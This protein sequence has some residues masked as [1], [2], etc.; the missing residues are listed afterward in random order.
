MNALLAVKASAPPLR[1]GLRVRPGLG[2]FLVPGGALMAAAL[3]GCCISRAAGAP[4]DAAEFGLPLPEGKGVMWEDPR[5]IHRVIVRFR[6]TVPAADR[7]HI[8]YWGSWWPD[9][10][11]PKDREPGGGDMGWMELGNW[12]KYGW[13]KADTEATTEGQTLSLTFRPVNASEFPKVKDYP[14]PFR[15][16]L[17]VRVLLDD[18]SPVVEKIEAL[19]DSVL[20]DRA[21]RLVWASAGQSKV[22]AIGVFNGQCVAVEKT[23]P[24]SCRAL[25]RVVSNPDPN[26]FDRTLAT[27]RGQTPFTFS[28]DDLGKG[29]LFLPHLGVAVLPE[30]DTRDYATVAAAQKASGT[31]TLY[32]RVADLPEQTWRSAWDGMPRKKSRI[33]FPMGL[34]GGRQRFRM[35]ADGSLSFRSNDHYL[36]GRPGQDTPRLALEKAPLHLSLG[37]NSRP[38][39]RTLQEESL[40]V[41]LTTW[42]VDGIAVQETALVT[43]LNGTQAA[44]PTPAADA[45]A[46]FMAR[47]VF[48]NTTDTPK[49]ATLPLRFR[50]GDQPSVLHAD[51]QGLLWSDQG[52]RGQVVADAVPS[53]ADAGLGWAFPLAPGQSRAV[54]LKVP[55]LVLTG[56]AEREALVHLE[57]DRERTAVAGYWRRQLNRSARLITPEP[58]LN[59][60]YRSHAMHLLVNCEREPQSDRRFARVGSFSYGAYGN[61]SCMMVVDLDRRGYHQEAQNCLDAWLHY[62]GTVGLPGSFASKEGVLYGAGGYEA[63]GYNQHHGW[64]LWMMAEHYRFTRDE[65]W[66]RQ[67]SSGIV[68]ACDWIVNETKRTADRHEL[69][70][71]LLPAGSLE[72]IGDWWTWLSTSCYTWRGLDSAAWALEQ[73]QHPDAPRLREAADAYHRNLLKNFRAAS[74]QSPVVRLRNGTAIPKIPSHVHRRGRCFGWICETLEGSLHLLITRALD[75]N[76]EEAG[77]ILQDYEDNLYLSNQY[78]YTLDDFDTY[79]FGRGG[80]SMQACLLLDVEPYLYRDDVKHALRALFNG[81]SVSYFPDVRMN[82]E[83]ALPD[84]AD[85]RGDQFKSSDESNTAGWLRALFVR[86]EGDTLLLGQAV[87]REWLQ[88]GR[89]CGLEH[90][91]SYFGP[92]SVVY[93][94]GKDQ[95]TAQVDGPRRNPPKEIRVRFRHPQGRSPSAVSVNDKPWTDVQ[96]D[97]VLLPGNIGAAVVTTRY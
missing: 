44:S 32:D 53:E 48:T 18:W 4:F 19:T 73:I 25:L 64:I 39:F 28:V 51:A 75:P 12:Y 71:G 55:Y 69:E 40:P 58:M 90:G 21:V 85:W 45:F 91:A 93:S 63:G 11:L 29:P 68:K 87:P 1:P 35:D 49:T 30:T 8:E 10:H 57:F 22:D 81:Q 65:A 76:S 23:S 15:Y 50:S 43:E 97:W 26:T 9:R 27:V 20:E 59:E 95:I 37:L 2:R 72:D 47:I 66:L 62:Q 41:C 86:E 16:T 79:W 96:G 46:V 14:A 7:V 61:E 52:L 83:H 92:T 78:G 13:R 6:D 38:S 94:A 33:Y 54:V 60:F 17:K 89:R 67:S 77:W 3:L 82:T 31:K 88:E 42:D 84:M 56:D 5:E 24:T 34:D 70:R 36:R 74:A 80:M